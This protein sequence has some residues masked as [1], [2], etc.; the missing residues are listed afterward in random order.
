[1]HHA[2]KIIIFIFNILKKTD[3]LSGVKKTVAA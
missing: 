1:M 2:M 3:Y